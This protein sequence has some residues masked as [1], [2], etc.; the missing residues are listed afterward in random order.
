MATWLDRQIEQLKSRVERC[1]NLCNATW[2]GMPCTLP[3]NHSVQPHKFRVECPGPD[4]AGSH[5]QSI[6]DGGSHNAG[7]SSSWPA[8]PA[9]IEEMLL[10]FVSR[11][12]SYDRE[13]G[14]FEEE[15]EEL[16]K[17]V[18]ESGVGGSV[19]PIS[20]RFVTQPFIQRDNL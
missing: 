3:A 1:M 9:L 7:Q 17:H 2:N 14:L 10:R 5:E 18:A 12:G 16:R 4:K 11:F 8:E 20:D 19:S 15:L 13:N 6:S